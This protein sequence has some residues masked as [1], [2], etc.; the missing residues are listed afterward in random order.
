LHG[1]LIK[2]PWIGEILQARKTWE[3]RGSNTKIR[4]TIVLIRSSS[5]LVVGT[6]DI[7][8]VVGPLTLAEMRKNLDRHRI[9]LSSLKDGLPYKKTYAWV[10][11]NAKQLEKPIAYDHPSGAVRWVKLPGK[12]LQL[13]EEKGIFTKKELLE[14]VSKVS[15]ETKRKRE[16]NITSQGG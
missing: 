15:R 3:I 11:R 4:G 5:G 16:R 1:L 7:V 2:D 8:G 13:A 9:P 6:C 14:M 12:I 10:L